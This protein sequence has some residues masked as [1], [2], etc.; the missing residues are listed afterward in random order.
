[1]VLGFSGWMDGGEVSTGTLEYL[2]RHLDARPLAEIEPGEFYLYNLPGSM[3]FT[4]MFRPQVLLEEG[5]I[6]E[7]N[8]PVN[9]FWYD[10]AHRL[11]LLTGREPHLHWS[12]YA[13][14]VFHLAGQFQVR[15]MVFVG[16]FAGL[17]P[18]T[19]APRITGTVS[20]GE[21][22][23]GLARA[24]V[25]PA[26]YRGPASISTYLAHRAGQKGVRFTTLV[27]E[28]PPYIQGRNPRCIEAVL[29][30]LG[31]LLG[32]TLDLE[33]LRRLG[34]E[35]ETKLNAAVRQRPEILEQIQK[36]EAA[37]DKDIFDTD[38]SE[39]KT[40]LEEKGIRLD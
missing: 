17:A 10:Q 34:D 30:R 6:R 23:A 3:E 2:I 22:K 12:R 9:I 1:M 28:I 20:H 5:E 37:Y 35:L 31:A 15:E 26:N 7:W 16:S 33:D 25:R 13:E 29:R 4:A 19:R 18:H 38:L 36:L 21:L 40:W 39:L 27:A 32:L 11:I 14:A 24:N 8:E